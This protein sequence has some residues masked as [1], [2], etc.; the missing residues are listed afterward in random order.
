MKTE[1]SIEIEGVKYYYSGNKLVI[2]DNTISSLKGVDFKD[3]EKLCIYGYN[4]ISSLNEVDFGNLKELWIHGK[5]TISS[6]NGID[7]KNLKELYILGGK[8]RIEMEQLTQTK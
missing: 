6:L 3:L 2:D 1:N 5:N 7:F 8:L 4:T